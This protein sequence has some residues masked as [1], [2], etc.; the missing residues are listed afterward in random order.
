MSKYLGDIL[1]IWS[2]IYGNY[3]T[4]Q[5]N[6]LEVVTG[7]FLEKQILRFVCKRSIRKCS[8]ELS[9]REAGWAEAREGVGC[10]GP[11]QGLWSPHGLSETALFETRELGLGTSVRLVMEPWERQLLWQGLIPSKD[12]T[13]KHHLW[14]M[15]K[16]ISWSWEEIWAAHHSLPYRGVSQTSTIRP[17]NSCSGRPVCSYFP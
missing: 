12:S 11:H 15:G 8:Q 10:S 14:Q 13:V 17:D 6:M 4:D 3:K 1:G 9:G 5:R 16:W 7:W 2:Q